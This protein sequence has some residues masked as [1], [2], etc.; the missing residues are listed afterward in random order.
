[1][2]VVSG[3]VDSLAFPRFSWHPAWGKLSPKECLM[4]RRNFSASFKKEAVQ[5]V[6]EHGR[7]AGKAAKELGISESALR[8]WIE[9]DDIEQGNKAGLTVAEKAELRE[10]K[11]ELQTVRME[12]DILKNT[13]ARIAALPVGQKLPFA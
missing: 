8:R 3:L 7:S 4:K 2:A 6:K 5:L 13:R 11:R 10:L 12:R 9:A 1:M